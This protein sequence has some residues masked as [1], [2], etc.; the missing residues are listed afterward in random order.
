MK[1][2]TAFASTSASIIFCTSSLPEPFVFALKSSWL[3]SAEAA[4]PRRATREKARR[5]GDAPV[6]VRE[7]GAAAFA[8]DATACAR[9]E[10][11]AT[12]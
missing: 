12:A 6:D 3:S 5:V 11:D 9:L 1:I 8:M 4:K 10:E 7:A 2:I